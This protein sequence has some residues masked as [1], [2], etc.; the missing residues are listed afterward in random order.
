MPDPLFIFCVSG[1]LTVAA[2]KRDAGS[3][4]TFNGALSLAS[5][6]KYFKSTSY[7]G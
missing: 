7:F 5:Q 6:I 4:R 3:L 1:L 2:K